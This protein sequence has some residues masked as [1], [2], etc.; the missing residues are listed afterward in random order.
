[1]RDHTHHKRYYTRGLDGC[2]PAQLEVVDEEKVESRGIRGVVL[3]VKT[4]ELILGPVWS[5]PITSIR[6]TYRGAEP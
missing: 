2:L 1:M 3:V 4:G 6:S 5:W